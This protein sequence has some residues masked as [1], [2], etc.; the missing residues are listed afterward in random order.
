[1]KLVLQIAG[2]IVLAGLVWFVFSLLFMGAAVK[3]VND[4][5]TTAISDLQQRQEAVRRAAQQRADQQRRAKAAQDLAT[6]QQHAAQM[7]AQSEALATRLQDQQAKEA[8][9]NRFYQPSASCLNPPT[10]ETQVD[11]GNVHI[12]AKREFEA[13][14]EQG[15]LR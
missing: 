9:W 1:M 12:R 2:G 11:C 3:V 15:Q 4:S 7:Q 8:A 5:T 10:W 13:R 6:R 14:W